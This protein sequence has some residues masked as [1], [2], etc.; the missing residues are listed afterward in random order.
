MNPDSDHTQSS[1]VYENLYELLR[2]IMI[3]PKCNCHGFTNSTAST[4]S[5]TS[6]MYPLYLGF[7]L[8]RIFC[9]FENKI[10]LYIQFTWLSSIWEYLYSFGTFYYISLYMHHRYYLSNFPCSIMFKIAVCVM[11]QLWTCA[12]FIL[13]KKLRVFF[14]FCPGNWQN[15]NSGCI[16]ITI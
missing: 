16:T 11:Q 1:I 5:A 3:S 2:C 14:V 15:F 7:T 4:T 12:C 10:I 9:T 8:Q 13:L 6:I